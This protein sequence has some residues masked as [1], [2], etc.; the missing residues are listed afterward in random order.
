MSEFYQ[1]IVLSPM[2]EG[3]KF[4]DL[5][6]S[7]CDTVNGLKWYV[8]CMNSHLCEDIYKRSSTASAEWHDDE[9]RNG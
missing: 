4:A 5:R 2:C 8:N 1:K 6:L 9:R 7:S 3:C